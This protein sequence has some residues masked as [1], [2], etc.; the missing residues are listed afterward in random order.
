MKNTS[1]DTSSPSVEQYQALQ[2]AFNYFNSE[3]FND[4]LPQVMFMLQR[5][6][7][8]HGYFWAESY[9]QGDQ[10]LDEIGLHPASFDRGDMHVMGTLVHEMCH[11]WQAHYGKPS[12]SGYHNKEWAEKMEEVGLTPKSVPLGKRTG[13]RCT[14]EVDVDGDFKVSADRYLATHKVINWL[15]RDWISKSNANKKLKIAYECPCG[16]KVWGKSGLDV[17]CGDCEESYTEQ[18]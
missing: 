17:V 4:E 1:Y 15:G 16:N 7:G 14:H 9:A 8:T 2:D 3:L 5:K 13:Q 6:K 11:L 12:R 10:K 18:A